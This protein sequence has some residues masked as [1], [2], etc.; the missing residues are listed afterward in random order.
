MWI[1]NANG[2]VK[3]IISYEIRH[4]IL[5]L[6][7]DAKIVRKLSFILNTVL[8]NAC[9]SEKE[10]DKMIEKGQNLGNL[11][12]KELELI[13]KVWEKRTEMADDIMTELMELL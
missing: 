7:S 1:K 5:K 8:G 12:D 4:K 9:Y 10:R 13:N 3:P 6:E 2:E 11:N